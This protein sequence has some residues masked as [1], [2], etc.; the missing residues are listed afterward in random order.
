MK[1][2]KEQSKKY[3]SSANDQDQIFW[4]VCCKEEDKVFFLYNI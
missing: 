3:I 2:D 1:Y 4:S